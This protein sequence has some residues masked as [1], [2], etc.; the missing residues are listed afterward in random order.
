MYDRTS[1]P[2]F[3]TEINNNHVQQFSIYYLALCDDLCTIYAHKGRFTFTPAI[4]LFSSGGLGVVEKD[5]QSVEDLGMFKAS[6]E[7]SKILP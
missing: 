4:I 7:T 2:L 3:K 5:C 6:R 1:C